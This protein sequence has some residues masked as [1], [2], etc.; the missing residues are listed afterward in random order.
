MLWQWNRPRNM[1][2]ETQRILCNVWIV[3]FRYIY[4][5]ERVSE[6]RNP[7]CT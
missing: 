3:G 5:Y 2:S 7:L 6:T 1:P 4:L